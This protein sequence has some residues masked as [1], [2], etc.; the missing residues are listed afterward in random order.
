[1]SIKRTE[2]IDAYLRNELD[3]EATEAFESQLAGDPSLREELGF[4]QQVIKGLGEFRKA[5]LKSR[6]T[7]INITTP[8][9]EVGQLVNPGL[10]KL[11]GA[12]VTATFIGTGIYYFADQD[13]THES[14]YLPTVFEEDLLRNNPENLSFFVENTDQIPET[15]VMEEVA[16]VSS[17]HSD[18]EAESSGENEI[19]YV[20][21]STG[22]SADDHEADATSSDFV[23]EV[24]LPNPGDGSEDNQFKSESAKIPLASNADIINATER[25]DIKTSQRSNDE[26]RYKYY[27][28]K[29]HLYGNFKDNPYE[30]L[31]INSTSSK[32][33]YLFHNNRYYKLLSTD[34]VLTLPQITDRVLI[35]ELEIVRNNKVD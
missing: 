4:Q 27:E 19:A 32:H 28:G 8:W 15:T 9:W 21:T 24:D 22:S 29:L 6:L 10:V 3:S 35:N 23:P 13:I 17:A 26:I 1:M 5:E 34:K 30:I 2:L 33:V 12:L 20:E 31:E 18:V 7:A 25:I 11:T 16:D 14:A